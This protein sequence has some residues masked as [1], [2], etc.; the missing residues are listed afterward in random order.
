MLIVFALWLA[1]LVPGA[2]SPIETPWENPAPYWPHQ[3]EALNLAAKEQAATEES[4]R[5]TLEEASTQ[6]T[7]S[8]KAEGIALVLSSSFTGDL[9]LLRKRG[10]LIDPVD[11]QALRNVPENAGTA[12]GCSLALVKWPNEYAHDGSFKIFEPGPFGYTVIWG[13][14]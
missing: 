1:N 6:A 10:V 12:D 13:T 14:N 2:A 8:A 5:A 4:F 11:P 7:C 9:D 3:I